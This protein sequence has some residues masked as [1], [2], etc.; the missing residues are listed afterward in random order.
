LAC[1]KGHNPCS[2][3][4]S[5]SPKG[6]RCE[7]YTGYELGIDG[8]TCLDVNECEADPGLCSHF[9]RNTDGGYA[10]SCGKGYSLRSDRQTCKAIGINAFLE[11]IS[12]QIVNQLFFVTGRALDVVFVTNE[13]IRKVSLKTNR[14]SILTSHTG[15]TV[16]GL[17][18]DSRNHQVYWSTGK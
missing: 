3:R 12:P 9:C 5:K 8:R 11:L 13:E 6:P 17:T 1:K 18:V 14:P 16:S 7:C 2:Q 15:L 4:C 10:C